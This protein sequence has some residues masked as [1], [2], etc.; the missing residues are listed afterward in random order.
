MP[1]SI[2]RSHEERKQLSE[3][4]AEYE[5]SLPPD[6]RHDYVP[7]SDG[8]ANVAMLATLDGDAAGCVF[9]THFDDESAIIQ[10]LYVRPNARGHGLARALM[11]DAAEHARGRGYRRL[12]LD[13][14]KGQLQAAYQLYLSLGFAECA[15]FGPVSYE[16]PT[17]MELPL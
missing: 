16:H 9:V 12:V 8:S 5:E 6:L 17:Y 14:D 11:N 10:R 2:V 4:V 1:T 3:L 7:V 15:P 13:T